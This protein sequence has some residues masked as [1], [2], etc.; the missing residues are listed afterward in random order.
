MKYK[1]SWCS[2]I[3]QK[4]PTASFQAPRIY[5][6]HLYATLVTTNVKQLSSSLNLKSNGVPKS[7]FEIKLDYVST[8][9]IKT[10]LEKNCFN[11]I[12][13]SKIKSPHNPIWYGCNFQDTPVWVWGY[14]VY[15]TVVHKYGNYSYVQVPSPGSRLFSMDDQRQPA[16][17]YLY[18]C[19]GWDNEGLGKYPVMLI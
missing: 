5:I 11:L 7:I 6:E 8:S 18:K 16:N 13:Q 3:T 15:K 2:N 17:I 12:I 9:N 10:W 1:S 14:V 4:Y 19:L